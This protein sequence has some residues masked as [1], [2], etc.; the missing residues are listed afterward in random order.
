L[1]NQILASDSWCKRRNAPYIISPV[2]DKD[3]KSRPLFGLVL[4]FPFTAFHT[5]VMVAGRTPSHL[6]LVLISRGFL[7]AL[8]EEIYPRGKQLTEAVLKKMAVR[9]K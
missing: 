1:Y 6:R 2:V 7:A 4:Y 3:K 9:Q 8:V 5:D